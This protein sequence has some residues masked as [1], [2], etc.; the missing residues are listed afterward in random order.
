MANKKRHKSSVH[1]RKKPRKGKHRRQ[2]DISKILSVPGGAQRVRAAYFTRL[3]PGAIRA[4]VPRVLRHP[5]FDPLINL[6]AKGDVKNV[7]GNV[8]PH[9]DMASSAGWIVGLLLHHKDKLS[10]FCS[11]EDRLTAAILRERHA[12]SMALLDEIDAVCGLSIWSIGV[13][14]AVCKA[15]NLHDAA[16]AFLS[17]A[18]NDCPDSG[19]FQV[20]ARNVMNRADDSSMFISS[21]VSLR[22][23]V[24]RSFHGELRDI[25]IYKLVPRDFAFGYRVDFENVLNF[26]KNASIVDAYKALLDL[27][28]HALGSEEEQMR[29]I[30]QDA[31]TRLAGE[32]ADNITDGLASCYGIKR[33]WRHAGP[34]FHIVDSY[35]AGHYADV[36]NAAR[37]RAP[38]PPSC[39]EFE[40]IAKAAVRTQTNP[41]E[42]FMGELHSDLVDVLSKG[43]GYLKALSRLLTICHTYREISWFRELHFLISRE[44]IYIDRST[45]SH[46]ATLSAAY[47][48]VNTPRK[49]LYLP[50][51]LRGPYLQSC[52]AAIGPSLS[53]DLLAAVEGREASILNT[54]IFDDLEEE[55][56][57][58]YEALMRLEQDDTRAAIP[59]LIQLSTSDDELIANEA[60]KMLTDAYI[61]VGETEKA[62]GLFVAASLRN[63]NV[64]PLFDTQ[65]ICQAAR[66]AI[67]GFERRIRL[68]Q[69][70][71][72]RMCS[73]ISIG[74]G[75]LRR[76]A[77]VFRDS[78]LPAFR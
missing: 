20:I 55:R 7:Y 56:A 65:R 47:S 52:R 72:L 6:T 61:D 49:A 60:T 67:S 21:S 37:R 34:A 1:S 25:L 51:S 22:K 11:L 63:T 44:S 4:N 50:E 30:A 42:G 46:L 53:L 70:V 8:A 45:D 13:R 38:A 58:K 14:G 57:R 23:Q 64:V 69:A 2:S 16:Q 74:A 78:P 35:S 27:C 5:F 33:P 3:S 39:T 32:I 40:V 24:L 62:I 36:C 31:I 17:S 28:S 77:R 71:F 19:L 66:D 12:K 54:P 68:D 29:E 15:G 75:L 43:A 48:A 10:T 73:A 9:T 18:L 26:E 41:Y 76:A 59:L